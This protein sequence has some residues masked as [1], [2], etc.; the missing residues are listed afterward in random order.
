[1]LVLPDNRKLKGKKKIKELATYNFIVPS[2]EHGNKR[3]WSC[4]IQL[5]S[6]VEQSSG[7][8]KQNTKKL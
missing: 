3:H 7:K 6:Q 1:M 5:A 4:G 2:F 8:N